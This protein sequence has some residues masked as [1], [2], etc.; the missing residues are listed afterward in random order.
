MRSV[1]T[2]VFRAVHVLQSVF[3]VLGQAYSKLLQL[4]PTLSE[5]KL[6]LELCTMSKIVH[7]IFKFPPSILMAEL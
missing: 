7:G 6:Y 4:V 2:F 5:C 1:Y 3:Q